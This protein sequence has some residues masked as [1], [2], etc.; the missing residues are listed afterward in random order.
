MALHSPE[1][2]AEATRL[3]LAGR[4]EE[5]MAIIQQMH[6]MPRSSEAPE[7]LAQSPMGA[8]LGGVF[9]RFGKSGLSPGLD[10]LAGRFKKRAQISLPDGA[11]Y[12]ERRYT[13]QAGSRNYKLYVPS[14]YCGAN[15]P[16]VIM[17]HGCRQSPDDF[18]VGTRMNQLAE[19]Q[20]CLVA[21]PGQ[22]SSANF[23]RCWNW[24]SADN[25]RRR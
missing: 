25:A 8:T 11:R 15:L 2:M 10:G 21:Y 4:L 12:E 16:L 24:F 9:D 18:A 20:I 23:A 14:R 13:N 6:Q 17:L 5:A 1:N 22:A 7:W 19:E 3:T